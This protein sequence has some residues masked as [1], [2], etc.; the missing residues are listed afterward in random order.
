MFPRE[1]SLLAAQVIEAYMP[2]RRKLVTAE[3]CTGGLVSAALA[4]IPGASAVLDR[5]FVSYN[6]LAKEQMLGVPNSML[7]KFG[8]VSPEIAEMMAAGAL[9]ASQSHVSVSVTGVAGPTGGTPERP[10]G[11]VYLGFATLE[12]ALFHFRA[13]FNGDRN[14]VQMQTVT[15]A[16]RL[17]LTLSERRA[18][19]R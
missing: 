3:S 15:E 2:Q 8:A 18:T 4:S 14:E 13:Q 9:S 7:E 5:S 6:E 10:V 11:L 16:L 19:E 1:V 17:L 12:G